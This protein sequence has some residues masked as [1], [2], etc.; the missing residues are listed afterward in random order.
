M[1]GGSG[2]PAR[3]QMWNLTWVIRGHAGD[4]SWALRPQAPIPLPPATGPEMS[5]APRDPP[6]RHPRTEGARWTSP[7]EGSSQEWAAQASPG[8]QRPVPALQSP[9]FS[10]SPI[11]NTVS[12]GNSKWLLDVGK[13]NRSAPQVPITGPRPL[14][15]SASGATQ[16]LD[17]LSLGFLTSE[18]GATK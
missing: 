7:R 3:D 15:S 14:L 12:P 10:I 13:V 16:E 5:A 8:L 6:G 1:R 17:H 9:A 2:W 18:N 11:S 4:C